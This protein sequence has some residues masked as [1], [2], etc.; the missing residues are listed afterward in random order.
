MIAQKGL[1]IDNRQN[2]DELYGTGA[3]DIIG[4]LILPTHHSFVRFSSAHQPTPAY[5]G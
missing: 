5:S 2:Q 1:V 3:S 4:A